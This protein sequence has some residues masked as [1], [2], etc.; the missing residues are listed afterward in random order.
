MSITPN[1]KSRRLDMSS[2][3]AA[4]S[5]LPPIADLLAARAKRGGRRVLLP[6]EHRD[7][8]ADDAAKRINKRCARELTDDKRADRLLNSGR[9]VVEIEREMER[10]RDPTMEKR[11]PSL[12]EIFD[13]CLVIRS[14]WSDADWQLR[15]RSPDPQFEFPKWDL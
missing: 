7:P 9:P 2:L 10:G 15:R 4:E 11:D 8:L 6:G 14:L 5:G 3:R 1:T 12:R 13:R